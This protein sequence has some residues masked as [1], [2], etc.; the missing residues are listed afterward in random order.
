AILL[1][2]MDSFMIY[3]EPFV[4][5]GGGPGNSTTFLSIDLVKMALGQFDLGPAAAFSIMY[6]LVILLVSYVFYTVMTNLDKRDGV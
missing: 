4:V 1:R 5:T 6:Y 2:F 3:T